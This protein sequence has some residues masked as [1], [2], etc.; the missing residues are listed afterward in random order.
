MTL[1]MLVL[2]HQLCGHPICV[3]PDRLKIADV[4]ARLIAAGC[5][6]YRVQTMTADQLE[7]AIDHLRRDVTCATCR[8]LPEGFQ[9]NA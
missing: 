4:Q 3:G 8:P 9:V 7:T 1:R 6:D 2:R 5:V